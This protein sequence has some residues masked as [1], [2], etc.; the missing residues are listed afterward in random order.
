MVGP[1][2]HLVREQGNDP[3]Q[4]IVGELRH[5]PARR[6]DAMLVGLAR[7]Q[8]LVALESLAEIVL[9]GEPGADQ[10]IQRPV[11]RG[12]PDRDPLRDSP[13]HLLGRQVLPREEHRLRNRPA[14]LRGRQVVVRQ[15]A[16]ELLEQLRAV[17]FHTTPPVR[18]PPGAPCPPSARRPTESRGRSHRR[19][20]A[21]SP[22]PR[23][24]SGRAPCP[25]RSACSV[26]GTPATGPRPPA[27]P[28]RPPPR[29]PLR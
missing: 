2:L 9:L 8:R 10:E 22:P 6:A 11:D 15:V 1:K 4:A 18:P 5:A 17:N 23:P 3:L 20:G 16:A 21:P 13:A 14:L 7:R 28:T 25:A 27:P 12:R 24:R 19:G 26:P 29:P